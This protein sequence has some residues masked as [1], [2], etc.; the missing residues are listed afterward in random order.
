MRAFVA[1]GIH[2]EEVLDSLA[3][4]QRELG[5]TGADLKAVE[6]QNLHF[7]LKFLGEIPQG[8]IGDAD[9]RL[10]SLKLQGGDVTVAGVG[11]FP[12]AS[13]PNV[14]W[15]GTAEGREVVAALAAE[16]IRS[17]EGIGERDSRPFQAHLT[18]A[19][20]RSGRNRDALT[21]LLTENAARSFGTFKLR[22]V[23]L[24]SSQLTPG[25]P[26]YTDLGVYGLP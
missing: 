3:T 8:D 21:R 20:V 9:R 26:V 5:A 11:A 16:V 12:S 17:L 25:G 7:T 6:R 19:R 18:V 4:F 13:R 15:V 1:L 24:K 23:T 2:S 22:S 14:V 10:R